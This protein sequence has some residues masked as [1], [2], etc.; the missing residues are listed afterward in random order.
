MEE[1]VQKSYEFVYTLTY[2]EIYEAF[3]ILNQKWG[4]NVKR[5]LTVILTVLAVFL[6]YAYYRDN[7]NLPCFFLAILD[8]LLLYY[9]LY[10]PILKSRR[11]AQKVAKQKGQYKVRLTKDGTLM[12][13]AEKIRLAGDKDARAIET[14]RIYVIRPD[15]IHTLCLPKRIMTADE[16][17]GVREILKLYVKLL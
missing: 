5:I 13:G 10:V 3:S 15:N 7:Q 11:G 6:L 14:D 2:D 17:V 1:L 12:L 4:K 16:V 9:L 8:I